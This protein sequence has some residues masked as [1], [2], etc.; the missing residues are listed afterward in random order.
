MNPLKNK[1]LQY[2]AQ[3]S[4]HPI[5]LQI[6]RAKGNYIYDIEGKSYLD[7]AAGVS[8]NTLGHGHPKIVEA[9]KK[10]IERHMHVMVYG[11]FIQEVCVQLC[12]NMAQYTPK[13]LETTYLVNSGA[14]AIEGAL[15]LAK[16]H[17][18]REEIIAYKMAYHGNTHGAMSI[19]GNESLKRSF[20]PLLP[21]VQFITFNDE[22]DL[23]A[24]TEKTACVVLETIQGAAGF[25]LPQN[26][27]LK[28]VKK[29]CEKT[30][31]LM[32]LDEIQPGFG[33]TG[34]LFAFEH[35]QVVPDILVM[36]KGMGGGMPI[37]AFMASQ[38]LMKCLTHDPM[39][40]HITTF[41]G[42]PVIAAAAL[43][44][45]TELIDGSWM[46]QIEE[47]EALIRRLLV[48]PEIKGIHGK[49]LMLVCELANKSYTLKIARRCMEKGLIVFW[50]LFSSE[51]LRLSPPLTITKE[52]IQ[53][54]CNIIIECLNETP[55]ISIHEKN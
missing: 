44:T 4:P 41:G 54:A 19:M 47:K 6:D 49:G 36:G 37:G 8:S 1:F 35:Y 21:I 9:I 52:E 43:A 15:K 22:K 32:I 5:A 34:K 46:N 42:H 48:H 28:K 20:R 40:G 24:I 7:F 29:Q 18:G 17:T 27:Y 12:Q 30:G 11:E 14:E 45:L 53:K 3:I 31:A 38:T 26:D 13:P 50:L 25:I 33:R 16:R 55:S 2:Q 10:Q 51:C 39:L 23:L